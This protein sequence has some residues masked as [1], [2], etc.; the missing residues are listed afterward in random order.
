MV[1][2]I[3]WLAFYRRP[4]ESRRLSPAELAHIESDPP[5]PEAP[6]PWI[7]LIARRET[8]AFAMG[9]FLTDPVWYMFLFW[10]PDFLEKRH[11]LDLKSFG[12][13]LVAIFVASDLGSIAG[14][15]LS[16]H[17]IHRGWP[18]NRA[19]KTVMLICALAVTPIFL[20]QYVD[21]LWIAV[22]IIGLATA[23]HQGWSANLYTIV[24]DVFP[25]KAVASVIGIGGTA[26]AVGGMIF[27]LYVGQVLQRI[28][29]YMP[30]FIVCGSLYLIALLIIH[31]LT[32]RLAPVAIE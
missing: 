1:W 18:L 8:W 2:L 19:R 10:L 21:S 12:P 26:G 17:L 16:S 24:S 29:T 3:A 28:G 25:R 22:A 30:I 13:P 14:G 7:K 9:K 32:P 15:W 23:G 31:M 4:R 20:A 11:G 27:S 6:M 5:D